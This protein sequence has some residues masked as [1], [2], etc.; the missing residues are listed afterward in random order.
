MTTTAR[1]NFLATVSSVVQDAT[2]TKV[3]LLTTTTPS[4]W[5]SLIT[6]TS[7]VKFAVGNTVYGMANPVDVWLAK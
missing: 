7:A 5:T 2:V 6:K 1:N 4:S 3:N